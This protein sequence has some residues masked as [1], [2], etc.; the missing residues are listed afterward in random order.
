MALDISLFTVCYIY[1]FEP[2]IRDPLQAQLYVIGLLF[3][4]VCVGG[5]VGWYVKQRNARIN[6]AR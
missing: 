2:S 5:S 1:A 4:A 3:P 6:A